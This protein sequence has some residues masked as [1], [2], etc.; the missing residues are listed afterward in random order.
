MLRN[1]EKGVRTIM[2]EQRKGIRDKID[3]FF[4]KNSMDVK[5]RVHGKNS[6]RITLTHVFFDSRVWMRKLKEADLFTVLQNAGFKKVY[7]R[8]GYDGGFNYTLD[9]APETN[10]PVPKAIADMGLDEPLKL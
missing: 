6:D 4:L 5:V 3:D 8:T 10:M 2:R 7:F 1:L 9:P